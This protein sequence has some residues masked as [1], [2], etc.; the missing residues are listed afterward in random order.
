MPT[1]PEDD[2]ERLFAEEEAAIRDDGFSRRVVDQARP[3]RPWRQT[4]LYGSGFAGAGFAVGGIVQLYSKAP[5]VTTW[6]PDVSS[7]VQGAAAET[8]FSGTLDGV[9]LAG[10]AVA[11][12]ITFLIAA[13][14]AAQTR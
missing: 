6:L 7:A 8:T 2:I 4:I 3:A 11:A 10:V 5:P 13:V 9:Q 14:A 1:E 12:G